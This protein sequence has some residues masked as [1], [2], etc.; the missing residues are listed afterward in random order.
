MAEADPLDYTDKYNTQL[1]QPEQQSFDAWSADQSQKVGRDVSKDKYDYDMQGWWKQ[2]SQDTPDGPQLKGGHLT[3]TFKKPNHPTFSGY[4]QYHGVDG[5]QGGNWTKKPDGS[6]SFM[7]GS[8]N[9][10]NFSAD[11]MRDYFKRVEPGNEL[12]LSQ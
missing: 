7:P 12:L 4:S 5:N 1:S 9:L 10:K 2:N 11:D 8:T 6:W 3:D